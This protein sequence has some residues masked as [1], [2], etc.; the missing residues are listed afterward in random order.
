MNAITEAWNALERDPTRNLKTRRI[1]IPEVAFYDMGVTAGINADQGRF[2]LIS[3]ESLSEYKGHLPQ[4]A[5]FSTALIDHPTEGGIALEIRLSQF[6]FNEIFDVLIQNIVETIGSSVDSRDAA[7]R[8]LVRLSV[9]ENFLSRVSPS[10]LSEQQQ[11]GL[12]GELYLLREHLVPGLGPEAAIA[13]W[14]GPAN[15]HQDYQFQNYAVETK[16]TKTLRPQSITISSELQLDLG[17][18]EGLFLVHI[19]FDEGQ[20]SGENLNTLIGS[21]R[22]S[23]ADSKELT[24]FNESLFMAG[25]IAE[26]S[27]RYGTLYDLRVLSCFHVRDQ[28][29]RIQE[30]DLPNGVGRVSYSLSLDACAEYETQPDEM[31][32]LIKE[33]STDND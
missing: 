26:H 6:E 24:P 13:S 21:L 8:V 17:N 15:A 20:S 28:F 25:Y 9:W 30:S 18:K 3:A 4:F 19:S 31:L 11:R 27:E 1:E 22:E 23:L 7:E 12:F 5:G 10:G 29:P 16:T 14:V 33:S 2:V 32:S